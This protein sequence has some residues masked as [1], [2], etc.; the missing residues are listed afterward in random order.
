MS[1][2][3]NKLDQLEEEAAELRETRNELFR[4]IGKYRDERD[5]L[6]EASSKL[7]EQVHK[8][9]NERD[10]LNS[11]IQEIKK[12]LGPLFD[13]L[14]E[15]REKLNKTDQ[16]LRKEYNSRPNKSQV[17]KDLNQTE[18]EIMTTPTREILDR[19]EQLISRA[20]KL[21]KTLEG[22]K[23]L[24]KQQVKKMDILAEKKATENEITSLRKEIQKLAERSQ[25]HHEKMLMFYEKADE[26]KKRADE[27][28]RRYVETIQ[29]VEKVKDEINMIMP[30]INALRNGIKLKDMKDQERRRM[31][32]QER[33]EQMRQEALRKM[34][35]GEKLSFED[36]KL[37]YGEEE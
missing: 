7:R 2:E 31:S 11:R 20:A 1:A 23:S 28:H 5:S 17:Q 33:K 18:W 32:V 12:N 35:S 27:T 22:F 29:E 9:K 16:V 37:I 14:D 36:M 34:E 19:E 4:R 24:E 13:D 8:H 30:Q 15:T 21:R 3:E 26:E 6:N 10:R 25:E